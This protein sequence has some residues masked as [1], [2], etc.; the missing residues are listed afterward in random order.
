LF[1]SF[2]SLRL[3]H[4]LGFLPEAEEFM[5]RSGKKQENIDSELLK[6]VLLHIFDSE[7]KKLYGFELSEDLKG[8]VVEISERIK[9]ESR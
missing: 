7:L 5:I 1:R 6:N 8:T 2:F 9:A 3:R 4:E